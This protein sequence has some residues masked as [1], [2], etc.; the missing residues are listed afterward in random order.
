[1]P[2][3]ICLSVFNLSINLSICHL[4]PIFPK[5]V[6]LTPSKPRAQREKPTVAPTMVW[7]PEMGSLKKV[8]TR[9]QM[10]LPPAGCACEGREGRVKNM[11]RETAQRKRECDL[12]DRKFVSRLLSLR[13][14]SLS[15]IIRKRLNKF[16]FCSNY[17]YT[18]IYFNGSNFL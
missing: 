16:I 12:C 15:L 1:M 8:A 13:M 11:L 10:A 6:Q 2:Y 4:L 14:F 5:V 9:F 7:V 18:D 17:F 3:Y